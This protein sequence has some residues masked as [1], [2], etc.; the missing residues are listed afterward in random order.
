MYRRKD[1][2]IWID[3][4][5]TGLNIKNDKIIEIGMVVTNC[6]LDLVTEGMSFVIRQNREVMQSMDDWNTFHHKKSGLY[7]KVLKSKISCSEAE[8][9]ILNFLKK[10][11]YRNISP[12]CGN[13]IYQDR[14]FL[15]KYMPNLE[16]FFHYRNID[17]STVKEL[18]KNWSPH[19]YNKHKKKL[20]HTALSDIKESIKELDFYRN[21]LFKKNKYINE[22]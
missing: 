11:A 8:K 20:N 7:D 22:N 19:F 5:M 21:I 10:I 1:L 4:E 2:L 9:N 12:L 18:V 14:I 13:S 3:L 17:V 6:N 15:K 16:Q